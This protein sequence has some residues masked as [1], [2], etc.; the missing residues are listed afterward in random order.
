MKISI[1]AYRDRLTL[2]VKLKVRGPVILSLGLE[3]TLAAGSVAKAL[4]PTDARLPVPVDPS[5]VSDPSS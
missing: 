1:R 4:A 5:E 3:L 2:I